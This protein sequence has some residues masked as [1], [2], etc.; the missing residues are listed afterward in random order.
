[1]DAY[2]PESRDSQGVGLFGDPGEGGD[3]L[4]V[5]EVYDAEFDLDWEL[6]P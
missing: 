2:P 4:C 5:E 6:V 3:I 1:M